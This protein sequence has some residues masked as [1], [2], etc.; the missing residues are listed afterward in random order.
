MNETKE[1][2]YAQG[3][4]QAPMRR[5]KQR[6]KEV[7]IENLKLQLDNDVITPMGFLRALEQYQV[8]FDEIVENEIALEILAEHP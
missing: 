5:R 8:A 2:S 4:T 7:I 3:R 1:S 6:E